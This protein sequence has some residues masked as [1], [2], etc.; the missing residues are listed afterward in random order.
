MPAASSQSRFEREDLWGRL[1]DLPDIREKI[2]IFSALIPDD[3]RTIVDVG[4]GD[5]AITNQLGRRWDVTGVDSSATALRHV[6]TKKV[7]ATAESLPF[8]DRSFD[9]VV[10]SQM[11]EHLDARAYRSAMQELLRVAGRYVLISVPYREDRR[12]R[13][14]RCPRCGWRGNVWG[15]RRSFSAESL[16]RDLKRFEALHVHLFGDL[17]DP[18][19]PKALV[20]T[21]NNVFGGFYLPTGQTPVCDEC[22]NDDF[23]G[24]RGFPPHSHRLKAAIDAVRRRPRLPYWIAV[25]AKRVD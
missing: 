18:P 19:W 9:L 13:V 7:L 16:I 1:H 10:S 4:C 22:G 15:H 6:T 3:V 8:D 14:I 12:M 20:W 2:R 11:L 21:F 5:G 25:L 23:R 24:V 17:Q